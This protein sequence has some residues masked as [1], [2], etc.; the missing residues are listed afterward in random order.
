MQTL[1]ILVHVCFFVEAD[2][3]HVCFFV[4]AEFTDLSPYFFVV[5]EFINLS[6]YFFCVCVCVLWQ[7]LQ[8]R[9]PVFVVVFWGQNLQI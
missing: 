6:P 7:N 2:Q 1:H 4:E 9:D 5:A 8:I 3:V